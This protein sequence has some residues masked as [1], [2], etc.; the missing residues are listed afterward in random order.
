MYRSGRSPPSA[1]IRCLGQHAHQRHSQPPSPLLGG[2]LLGGLDHGHGERGDERT[3]VPAALL[4]QACTGAA[5]KSPS[6]D[7]RCLNGS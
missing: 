7:Q 1:D 3:D 6:G 4:G 2:E 5:P